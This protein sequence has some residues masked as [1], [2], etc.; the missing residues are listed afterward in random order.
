MRIAKLAGIAMLAMST[1]AWAQRVSYDYQDA[2][3]FTNLKTYAWA[4]S[5]MRTDDPN[6]HRIMNAVDAQMSSK[7]Y[8]RVEREA[9]PDV[10]LVYQVIYSRDLQVSGYSTGLAGYRVRPARTGTA[11]VERT[12]VGTLA[13]EVIK[14]KSG[15]IIWRGIA[16]KDVDTDASPEKRDKNINKAVAKLFKHYPAAH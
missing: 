11:R 16:T 8:R 14:T 5:V 4:P 1:S 9:N 10:L 12:L 15:A 6:S 13:I 3:A 7:G 2:A